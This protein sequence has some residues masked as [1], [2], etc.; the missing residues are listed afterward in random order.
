MALLNVF[1]EQGQRLLSF[2]GEDGVA[3]SSPTTARGYGQCGAPVRLTTL[4]VA[5][6]GD[7]RRGA[8]GPVAAEASAGP[9]GA[10]SDAARKPGSG[11]G[12]GGAAAGVSEMPTLTVNHFRHVL[13]AGPSLSKTTT[14]G[15]GAGG[16]NIAITAD[17]I[18]LAAAGAAGASTNRRASVPVDFEQ[19]SFEQV[20]AAS[21]AGAGRVVHRLLRADPLNG[22]DSTAA[23]ADANGHVG[24]E[25]AAADIRSDPIVFPPLY[26]R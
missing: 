12:R 18:V 13:A 1:S 24:G 4:T 5:G 16:G 25:F 11:E 8:G 14:S 2:G 9:V 23:A 26:A 17:G 7:A 6:A 21:E 20:C 15:H 22:P 19:L 10:G 3:S